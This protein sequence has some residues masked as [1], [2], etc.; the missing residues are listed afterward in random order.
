MGYVVRIKYL[1]LYGDGMGW[2]VMLP[3]VCVCVCVCGVVWCGVV[4]CGVVWCGVRACVYV[5]PNT[6]QVAEIS[7]GF[8]LNLR[9][10]ELIPVNN[11]VF[12][13]FLK[14]VCG[15]YE[16]SGSDVLTTMPPPLRLCD[17][18]LV[19]VCYRCSRVSVPHLEQ[20]T[21]SGELETDTKD[22]NH[23]FVTERLTSVTG[24]DLAPDVIL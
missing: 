3:S 5:S 17:S 16:A 1:I 18:G 23:A 12:K 2:V 15:Y 21:M 7:Y 10:V 11:F 6:S 14:L 4:W 19:Q 9:L 8:S 24:F 13:R 22:K 20:V